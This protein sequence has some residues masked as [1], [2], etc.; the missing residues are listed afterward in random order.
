MWNL[1][2]LDDDT[3][4][5]RRLAAALTGQYGHLVQSRPVA[6]AGGVLADLVRRANPKPDAIIIDPASSDVDAP[7]LIAMLRHGSGRPVLAITAAPPSPAVATAADALLP[8]PCSPAALHALL[9]AVLRRARPRPL[10]AGHLTADLATRTATLHGRP[11]RLTRAEFD[12]LARLLARPG[13]IVPRTAL[14]DGGSVDVIL[15][16]LRAK[17]GETA[18]RPHYLHTHRGRGVAVRVPG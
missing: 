15:S 5:R 1:V 2:I 18:G 11:L 13:A 9:G 7:A 4:A 10:I 12:L 17:L 8:K 16:R 6:A 14:S 3:R